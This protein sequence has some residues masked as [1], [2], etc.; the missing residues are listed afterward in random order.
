MDLIVDLTAEFG[1]IPRGT[2]TFEYVC[3]PILDH[4]VPELKA[5]VELVD[6]LKSHKGKIL[7]HCAVGH[8]RSGMVVAALVIATQEEPDVAAAIDLVRKSRNGV[9]LNIVQ[10]QLLNNYAS[11]LRKN[12]SSA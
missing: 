6:K 12:Q 7:V 8:G 10:M 5:L 1:R 3:L 4:S 11:K 2:Y 9:Q